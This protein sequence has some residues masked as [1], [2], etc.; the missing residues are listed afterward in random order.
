MLALSSHGLCAA[1]VLL[2]ALLIQEP[3]PPRQEPA[4]AE[5]TVFVADEDGEPLFKARVSIGMTEQELEAMRK[6]GVQAS[7][8]LGGSTDPDG[9]A[10]IEV[11]AGGE[12]SISVSGRDFEIESYSGT[13]GP[14]APGER[15]ELEVTLRTRPDA[16]FR[17]RLLDAESKEPI[18]GAGISITATSGGFS[19]S[20]IPPEATPPV[21]PA[22]VSDDDGRFELPVATWGSARADIHCS[23]YA[24][25]CVPVGG[26]EDAPG[27]AAPVDILLGR[28][29]VLEIVVRGAPEGS[30]LTTEAYVPVQLHDVASSASRLGGARFSFPADERS[31]EGGQRYRVRGLPQAGPVKLVCRRGRAVVHEIPSVT[32]DADA[33][34]TTV[35]IDLRADG[36]IEGRVTR[37]DGSPAEGRLIWVGQASFAAR[38]QF[39]AYERPLRTATTDGEGRFRFSG[40][41]RGEYL[42]GYPSNRSGG[43]GPDLAVCAGERVDL[44]NDPPAADVELLELQGRLISGTLQDPDGNPASGFVRVGLV[45][46]NRR[47]SDQINVHDPEGRFEL[48]PLLPGTYTLTASHHGSENFADA[49]SMEVDA[50][51]SGL[52]VRLRPGGS[53]RCQV[54]DDGRAVSNG[55]SIYYVP[56]GSDRVTMRGPGFG[57]TPKTGPIEIENLSVGEHVFTAQTE[58][59]RMSSPVIAS[60]AAGEVTDGVELELQPVGTVLV[61]GIGGEGRPTCVAL[62]EGQRIGFPAEWVGERARLTLPPGRFTVRLTCPTSGAEASSEVEVVAGET[63]ERRLELRPATPDGK[64]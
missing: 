51:A 19:F 25:R 24:L 7:R 31:T 32:L 26:A 4:P 60:V 14:L 35:E 28:E 13:I 10:V 11:P 27:L 23:G 53:V 9:L 6:A 43:G 38:T 62:Y 20:S 55:V 58:D 59:G 37:E 44:R 52:E 48:G 57:S 18:P 30:K 29:H 42:V 61:E 64:D 46:E 50:G 15:L 41:V 40:L 1:A 21:D 45:D 16:T 49:L 2:P 8:G 47:W 34:E 5:V 63:I 56:R 3:E 12:R 36:V 33:G 54:T 22:A 17:G 39:S